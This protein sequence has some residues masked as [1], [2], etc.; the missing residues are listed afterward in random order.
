MISQLHL[1]L[2]L[3]QNGTQNFTYRNCRN[4]FDES[5]KQPDK[6]CLKRKIFHM[7]VSIENFQKL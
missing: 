7:K 2:E 4:H 1:K 3:M 5:F 6:S